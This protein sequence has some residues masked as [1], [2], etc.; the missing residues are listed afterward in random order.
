MTVNFRTVAVALVSFGVV[1]GI[2]FGA[3]VAYGRSDP[4]T[5]EGGLTAQQIQS[6]LSITGSQASSG[7]GQNAGTGTQGAA[8]QRGASGNQASSAL[9][10]RVTAVDGQSLTVET[11]QGSQKVTLGS[12]TTFTKLTAGSSSD[13]RE[14]QSVLATGSRK[15]DGSIEAT[16]LFQ[17][18]PELQVLLAS[19]GLTGN[20]GAATPGGSGR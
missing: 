10:G 18:T 4:K 19:A 16:A 3:G 12:N 5:V 8:G 6:L 15:E 17:V 14:G 9:T 2:T 1:L 11:R 13:F 7:T 20:I